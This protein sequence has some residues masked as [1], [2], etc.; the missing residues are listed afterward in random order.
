MRTVTKIIRR[1]VST[2]SLCS[3][4]VLVWSWCCPD[5]L[6]TQP[7]HGERIA[8]DHP[9]YHMAVAADRPYPE[10][11]LREETRPEKSPVHSLLMFL[12]G[13]AGK[14]FFWITKGGWFVVKLLVAI[15]LIACGLPGGEEMA[16]S[17]GEGVLCA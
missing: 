9:K 11:E 5:V 6:V 14:V 4:L 2:A 3:A 7:A 12:A 13:L 16:A 10:P 15:I 17:A 8:Y 1:A